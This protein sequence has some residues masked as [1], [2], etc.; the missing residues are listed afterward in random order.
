MDSHLKLNGNQQPKWITSLHL[1]TSQ[2]KTLGSWFLSGHSKLLFFSLLKKACLAVKVSSV[3]AS[4]AS[5]PTHLCSISGMRGHA[6]LC[7]YST[8]TAWSRL[9]DSILKANMTVL[10]SHTKLPFFGKGFD[11]FLN[12][13]CSCT[14]LNNNTDMDS[15]TNSLRVLP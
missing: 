11:D 1:Q 8:C 6:G 14:T 9:E 3:G 13:P 7:S 15:H 4:H 2:H 5:L 10:A 12:V